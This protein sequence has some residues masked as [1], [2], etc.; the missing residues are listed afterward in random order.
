MFKG[1]N[2]HSEQILQFEDLIFREYQYV[3][4]KPKQNSEKEETGHRDE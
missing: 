3:K 2:L 1:S 4:L